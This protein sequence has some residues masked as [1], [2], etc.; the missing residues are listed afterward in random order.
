MPTDPKI[1]EGTVWVRVRDPETGHEYDLH[2]TANFT[3]V[4]ILKDYPPNN[5]RD[6]R[7]MKPRTD[8]DG[9]PAKRGIA[10]PADTQGA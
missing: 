9:T 10:K 7:P 2:R 4:E 3:G 6:P 5:K 1:P 8:K